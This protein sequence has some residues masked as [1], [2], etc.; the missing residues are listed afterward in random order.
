MALVQCALNGA[1]GSGIAYFFNGDHFVVFSWNEPSTDS[2]G[3]KGRA[4][5]GPY[6]VGSTWNLP[7]GLHPVGFNASFDAALSADAG[8]SPT[9]DNK[10]YLFKGGEYVR[11]DYY[12]NTP[13]DPDSTGPVSAWNLPGLF[14]SDVRGALNGKHSRLGY[15]Y[16]FK[17][18]TYVR[19]N[20]A[21]NSVDADYPRPISSL[22]DMPQHFWPGVDATVDGDGDYADHGYLFRDDYYCRFNWQQVRVDHGPLDVWGYWPGVLELLLAAEAKQVALQWLA[23]AAGQLAH[24]LVELNTGVPSPFDRQLMEQALLTH[25][26]VSPAAQQA[27]HLAHLHQITHNL[28]EIQNTL[29]RLHEVLVFRDTEQVRADNPKLVA[30]DGP[31][32]RAYTTFADR[33]HLTSRFVPMCDTQFTAAAVLIHESVHFIDA[34]A[35]AQHDS[36]EWYVTGKPRIKVPAHQGGADVDVEYYDQITADVA[37]HNPSSY[38]AF[39]QHVHFQLDRRLGAEARRASY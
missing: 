4:V 3:G 34:G 17:D 29:H 21:A 39:S 33:I 6:P 1:A 28:A 5:G 14:H 20:W 15:A 31:T 27:T 18:S 12:D 16:F 30:A 9:Y 36:P 23:D 25:F 13:R 37:V 32:V 26:H 22:V 10:M 38:S 11:Y 19:Y 24:Y 8:G 2:M 35:T 7:P